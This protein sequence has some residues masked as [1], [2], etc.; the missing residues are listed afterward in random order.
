MPESLNTRVFCGILST[1]NG[2]ALCPF[3][4]RPT[5]QR[6]NPDTVLKNFPLWCKHC[7]SE[8]I[9]NTGEPEPKS[10]SHYAKA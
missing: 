8:A 10:Q 9:V 1:R 3:C 4:G 5:G 7:R 6:I 2:R